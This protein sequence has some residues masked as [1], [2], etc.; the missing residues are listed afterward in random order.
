M[1][2]NIVTRASDHK[3][4][5]YRIYIYIYELC[6]SKRIINNVHLKLAFKLPNVLAVSILYWKHY[7]TCRHLSRLSV[8]WTH[9]LLS[10]LVSAPRWI[11]LRPSCTV[12]SCYSYRLSLIKLNG[13][14]MYHQF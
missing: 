4:Y 12:V 14:Y 6:D 11:N 3:L 8:F 5:M 1:L 7:G 9:V 13:H 2:I 10:V